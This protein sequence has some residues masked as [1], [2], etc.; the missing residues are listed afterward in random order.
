[1]LTLI[2]QIPSSNL[3]SRL[4]GGVRKSSMRPAASKRAS[5]KRAADEVRG[6]AFERDSLEDRFGFLS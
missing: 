6:D 4:L 2:D 1:M 5:R 3:W